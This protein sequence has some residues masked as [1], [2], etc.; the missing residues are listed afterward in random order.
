MGA[1]ESSVST[2]RKIVTKE[3]RIESQKILRSTKPHRFNIAK[4]ENLALQGVRRNSE[5]FILPAG[6]GNAMV[7][8]DSEDYS[9]KIDTLL[10]NGS[11]IFFI[12]IILHRSNRANA[13]LRL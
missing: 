3:I 13:G 5:T 11:Y 12:Y 7:V 2:L 10:K 8:L 6:N 9:F 4:C 1:I